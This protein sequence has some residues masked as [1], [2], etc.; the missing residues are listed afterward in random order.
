LCCAVCFLAA[1]CAP[2][3]GAPPRPRAA[4][5]TLPGGPHL[6][7]VEQGPAGG[8]PVLLLH[9]YSDS[10]FSFSRLLPLLPGDLR[11]LALDQRGHG[12]SAKDQPSHTFADLAADV[13]AFLDALGVER[14]T[15]VGHSM[16][17]M[18]AQRVAID[19][20][21]RV[22]RLVLI[23][24]MTKGASEVCRALLPEVRRLA[25]PVDPAFV[26]EFQRSTLCTPV[27]EA[28]F[29]RAVA[30]SLTVPAR[31]WRQVHEDF[32]VQDTTPALGRIR[33]PTLVLYGERDAIFPRTDQ[34][35]LAQGIPGARLRVF[36]GIGHAP[37]W[38]RPELVAEELVR[39]LRAAGE[40]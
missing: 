9:G 31:I 33:A 35:T 23:G 18:V 12:Q 25:D 2:D 3:A 10:S 29:E 36:E 39:F 4:Q 28:F 32:V 17:S 40:R 34:E 38:E 6:H 11:L 19:H 7:Y 22:R 21:E 26:R 14:A 30:E 37:H 1:A 16:G 20:P 24:S 8:E 27:P 13:V 15:I 5:V